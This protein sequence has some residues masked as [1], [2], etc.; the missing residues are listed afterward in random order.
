VRWTSSAGY[1][2][3]WKVLPVKAEHR[4]LADGEP[5]LAGAPVVLKHAATNVDLCCDGTPQLNDFGRDYETC[6]HVVATTGKQWKLLK[7]FGGTHDALYD[8]EGKSPNHFIFLTGN[9]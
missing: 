5:V 8:V 1:N 4:D 7:E 3:A 9:L 6:C 2:S